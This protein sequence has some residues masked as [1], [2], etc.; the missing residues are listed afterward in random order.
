M[1]RKIRYED[2]GHGDFHVHT[3]YVDGAG[4]VA[5]YCQRAIQNGLKVIA[6]TEHVRRNL[7][8]NFDDFLSDVFQAKSEFRDI[9]ILSGCEAKVLNTDGELD[10]ATEVVERCDLVIGVFHSFNHKDKESYLLALKAMLRNP[11]VSI[12]GHPTLFPNKNHLKLEDTEIESAIDICVRENILIERNLRYGIPDARFITLALK[13][14]AKFVI[15][16]DA[17]NLDELLTAQKWFK[18]KEWIDKMS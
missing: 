12:W 5:E 16:S 9:K 1:S 6:F 3:S 2:T 14:G 8:Y 15:S 18:E 7:T 17:H 13:R 11:V 10:V 4:T